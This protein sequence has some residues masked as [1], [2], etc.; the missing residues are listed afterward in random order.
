MTN[1]QK[2]TTK[3]KP[4]IKQKGKRKMAPNQVRFASEYPKD[5]NATQAAIRAG[6]SPKTAYSQGQRL[7]KNVEVLRVIADNVEVILEECKVDAVYVLNQAVKL[8]E[9]CMQEVD[10][11]MV[12]REQLTDAD[13]RPVF[14]F[15][16]QGA[17]KGLELVGK[18]VD[19]QAFKENLSLEGS[20]TLEQ[21]VIN[22]R[23][24]RNGTAT[25]A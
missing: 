13:E 10:P 21:F 7:L 3:R 12:G 6:Y 8:H 11:V 9:R 2:V 22:K 25:T 1:K 5:R 19:V 23:K 20:L 4:P 16:A 15:N 18:H 24:E 14:Q 17:A